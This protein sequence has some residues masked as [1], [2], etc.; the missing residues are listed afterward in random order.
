MSIFCMEGGIGNG[1]C[2]IGAI[3][4]AGAG[5]FACIPDIKPLNC[6]LIEGSLWKFKP[7]EAAG[8]TP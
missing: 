5:C 1:C 4:A 8:A 3:G 2:I 7:V 6:A